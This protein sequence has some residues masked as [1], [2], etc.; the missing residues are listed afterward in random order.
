[1]LGQDK[2]FKEA[3]GVVQNVALADP[4][5]KDAWNAALGLTVDQSSI[6]EAVQL[7][8]KA[9]ARWP[10]SIHVHRN[11]QSTS[12]M[13]GK[14][15]GLLENYRARFESAD[16]SGCGG[17]RRRRSGRRG[18]HYPGAQEPIARIRAAMQALAGHQHE[19]SVPISASEP[20]RPQRSSPSRCRFHSHI[21]QSAS[22]DRSRARRL[23]EKF[24]EKVAA[25]IATL[26][27]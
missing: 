23:M 13:A 5:N 21:G 15:D 20:S 16:S 14:G 19:A 27:P 1:M 9:V 8:E 4:E 26:F 7:T 3:M 25:A 2:K 17:L 10:N 22:S 6:E 11:D 24:S 18:R 12:E